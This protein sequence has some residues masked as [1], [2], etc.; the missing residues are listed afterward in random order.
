MG[1]DD[2]D[3]L[4]HS[5]LKKLESEIDSLKTS[6]ST[7]KGETLKTMQELS[8]SL[9]S[10]INVFSEAKNELRIEDEEK[11]LV[12]K[13]IGPI[14]EKLDN[15]LDQNEK[16][17]E[18]ILS[19]AD[20]IHKLEVKIG[21]IE[22]SV[23]SGFS[24][25]SQPAPPPPRS[26]FAEQRP[27]AEPRPMMQQQMA[28]MQM[29]PPQMQQSDPFGDSGNDPFG[30]SGNDPF[31]DNSFGGQSDSSF[32][33]SSD[34]SFGSP[35]GSQGSSQFGGGPPGGPLG[36]PPGVGGSS[37]GRPQPQ[38]PR[39]SQP[40]RNMGPPSAGPSGGPP[41]GP[42][43]GPPAF[44]SDMPSGPGGM[45]PPPPPKPPAKKKGFFGK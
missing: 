25:M 17:A 37:F 14:I 1:D 32:G 20:M 7:P 28:P 41:G 19:I 21:T 38:S 34:S 3:L 31:G 36:G 10:M 44:G 6:P 2:Y 35:G 43:G 4:P 11:E 16:I 23:D 5:E 15:L 42:L 45:P 22:S 26:A 40:P 8:D 9:K 27:M 33:S 24:S 13:K 39:G 18:G 30:D 29:P 12:S